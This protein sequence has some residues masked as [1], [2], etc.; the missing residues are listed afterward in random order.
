MIKQAVDDYLNAIY[1][2]FSSGEA[3]EESYYTALEAFIRRTWKILKKKEPRIIIMPKKADRGNPDL[4][5]RSPDSRLIGYIEAKA[6]Q[7]KLD[8][9]EKSEQIKRF[10]EVFPNFILTNFLEFRFY[11]SGKRVSS[12]FIGW[13]NSLVKLGAKL[14]P[15]LE[16]LEKCLELFGVFFSFVH[17][18]NWNAKDLAGA[19]AVR[20]RFFRDQV[21]MEE[22]DQ[23]LERDETGSH[24]LGFYNAFKTYLIHGLGKEEF[25]DLY[26]Q[27]LTFGLFTAATRRKKRLTRE[28]AIRYIPLTSGILHDIFQFISMGNI[29]GQLACSLDDIVEVLNSVDAS[30]LL[31][32]YYF[33]E[34][35]DDP[36]LHFYETFLSQYDPKVREKRGVYYT[37]EPVVWFIVR[38]LHIIL[39]EKLNRPDGLADTGIKILD[40]A[41]GTSTFLAAAAQL[42]VEEY[43]GTYGEGAKLDFA[44]HYLL[45]N[46]YGFEELMAPYAVGHLKM[47]FILEKIGVRL[48]EGERFNF[49]LT[50]TL[51]MEDTEQSNLPGM[52][53]LSMESRLAAAIKKKTP[54]TVVLGNPPYAGHSLNSS[55]TLVTKTTGSRK[56]KMTK[57][58]TWIGEQIE[59][60][61]MVNGKPL[62]EKNIKWLQDDYVKFIR[63]A[64]TKI[65]ENGEGVMGF[66][67]NHAYLDNPTFRGMRRSLLNSF[68]EIY[69]LDLHGNAL[70]KEKCPDGS[71]DEN[72]F[73]I[74]QGV[75]IALFIK[76]KNG[77]EECRVYH[78]DAWGLRQEKYDLLWGNDISTLQ[79]EPVSPWWEFYL[80]TPARME[81]ADRFLYQRFHKV[82]DI[83]P[84]HSVGIVTARDRLTIKE[85]ADSVHRTI[86]RFCDLD[87]ERVR[88]LFGL[89]EDTRDWRVKLAQKDIAASGEDRQKVVPILYRP[90]DIRYTYYTGRSRGF[91]CMPRPEVMKHMLRDN[92]ALI[93]VRQVAE[94][95]FNH[96]F[97][98]DT[99]VESRITTSNKGIAYI[100]PLFLYPGKNQKDL[101]RRPGE[102]S[103][104]QPNLEPGLI[105]L[106]TGKAGFSPAP[107]A[108]QVFYYIYAVLFSNFYREKYKENLKIDF[109]RIPFTS[110]YGL[111]IEMGK[112]GERLAA[113]HLMK[114]PE[115]NET[116]CRFEKVGK[117]QVIKVRFA[118]EEKEGRVYINDDQYFSPVPRGVW[119]YKIAG[120]QVMA[121]WLKMHRGQ[122]LGHKEVRKF[123][124]IVHSIQLTIQYQGQIDKLYP[125][126]EERLLI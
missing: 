107:S 43:A 72:M 41:A 80:F 37:P 29:P 116:V 94:G 35:G 42:A 67:T 117:N 59:N 75:A 7:K 98:A 76:R 12:V 46:L 77:G 23:A 110:D 60:Y 89:G 124:K 18:R 33:D 119:E 120:Y 82:T 44:H 109:P 15:V 20:T 73:D 66:I 87:E 34:K 103:E 27:T 10:L 14:M 126:I 32:E 97:A 69:I 26:S 121:K 85:D 86:S 48:N 50:N 104:K 70:K 31:N 52:S 19:L 36:I 118:E 91:H 51:E 58:K 47:S 102:P 62:A 105:A 53:T 6:P 13:Q 115:L 122:G 111:F 17:P 83:F 11:R 65:D 49:Y 56:S 106:L 39:K 8:D 45:D 28:N 74:R 100:F 1:E 55:E 96:C 101:F 64:Q 92:I 112:L 84:V 88:L 57:V 71:T 16:N 68:D 99:I 3:R 4:V 114:S 113:L 9:V 78:A 61:K 22:L 2:I 123:I 30:K 63:F 95:D 108:E 79:W 24:I 125:R 21:V 81:K 54:I 38:S 90:F 5:I 25:A 40:P 93:T